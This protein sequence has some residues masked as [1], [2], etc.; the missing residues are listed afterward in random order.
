MKKLQNIQGV[1]KIVCFSIKN[2][3]K[4]IIINKAKGCDLFDYV[5]DYG[6]TKHECKNIIRQL[7]EILENI[8]E[9]NIYHLDIKP[10]NIIYD[11]ETETVNLIDFENR[12]TEKYSAPEFLNDQIG[13]EKTEMWSVG[14]TLYFMLTG[15]NL[16]DTAQDIRKLNIV[17]PR[18]W[19]EIL[20]DFMYGLLNRNPEIRFTIGDA[21][22]H[23]WLAL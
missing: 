22:N 2:D 5:K 10:E 16:F 8:H 17:F 12:Y 6:L 20:V 9:K 11:Y 21:L 3:L 4:Y 7:L 14:S 1:P 19:D 13:N 15:H 18:K 23:D